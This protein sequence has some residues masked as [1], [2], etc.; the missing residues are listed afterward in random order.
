MTPFKGTPIP[1]KLFREPKK[2]SEEEIQQR[3]FRKMNIIRN[4]RLS[5]WLDELP[6]YSPHVIQQNLKYIKNKE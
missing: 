2:F 5:K 4:E 3:E 6:Y 1:K